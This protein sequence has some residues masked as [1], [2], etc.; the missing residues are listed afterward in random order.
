M[1]N[2]VLNHN[3]VVIDQGVTET[4]WTD[5][6]TSEKYASNTTWAASHTRNINQGL[7]L[8]KLVPDL[9]SAIQEQQTIID[10]LKS[11]IETLEG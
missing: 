6:K 10:D 2:V 11:R 1:S 9:V 4:E 8:S 5:G 7:D 3:S